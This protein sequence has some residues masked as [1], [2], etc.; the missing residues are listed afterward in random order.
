MGMTLHRDQAK[1]GGRVA[2]GAAGVMV[3]LAVASLVFGGRGAGSPE[4]EPT[5]EKTEPARPGRL[6]PGF[7]L[8][9]EE[10][11]Y[12]PGIRPEEIAGGVEILFPEMVEEDDGPETRTGDGGGEGGPPPTT[13][14][15]GPWKYVGSMIG[16]ARR[17]AVVSVGGRERPVAMGR[18][19]DGVRLVTVEPEYIEIDDGSGVQRISRA[20]R[21]GS[22]VTSLSGRA[23]MEQARA[24]GRGAEEADEEESPAERYRRL[25]EERL[26]AAERAGRTPDA[27]EEA[28]ARQA[29]ARRRMRENVTRGVGE[30]PRP[31]VRRLGR[32]EQD[33]N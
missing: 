26:R 13:E 12:I 8:G 24:D 9:E 15:E 28:R 20:P 4:P 3:A 17:L 1:R 10:E 5:G 27:A 2:Q 25:R 19:L 31:T 18:E 21:S 11:R 33:D 32:D 6:P 14:P 23:P 29:E 16:P 22:V 7:A 30:S